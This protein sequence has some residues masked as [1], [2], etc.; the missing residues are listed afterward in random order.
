M[1]LKNDGEIGEEAWNKISILEKKVSKQRE[2][3]TE[4]LKIQ[5]AVKMRQKRKPKS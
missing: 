5:K 1:G 4:N 3:E 2:N